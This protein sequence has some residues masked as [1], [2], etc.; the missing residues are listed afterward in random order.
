MVNMLPFL[1]RIHSPSSIE[2]APRAA[3]GRGVTLAHRGLR[4][5]QASLFERQP[6]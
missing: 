5:D 2:P 1:Y 6:V 3:S 4:P